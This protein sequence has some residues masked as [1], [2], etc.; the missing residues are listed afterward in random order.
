MIKQ[1]YTIIGVMSGTSLDGVDLAH[2]NIT[3]H[4]GEY[5][6]EIKEAATIPY[7]NE[8]LLTLKK[9]VG[10]NEMQLQ[11][12]DKDYTLLLSQ[13]IRNFIKDNSLQDIDA[14]CLHGHTILHQP[15]KKLTLQ[16]GNLP[17]IAKLTG[18]RVVCNFRVQDV[19]MG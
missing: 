5:K 17:E 12:L 11:Q 15:A 1:S 18:Q 13:I 2:I 7:D 6:Y 16:I 3:I 19:R 8:W 14:V 10:F 4:N 9:A